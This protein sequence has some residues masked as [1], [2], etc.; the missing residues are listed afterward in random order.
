MESSPFGPGFSIEYDRFGNLVDFSASITERW[1][2]I[3]YSW[4][5]DTGYVSLASTGDYSSINFTTPATGQAFY[6]FS[7]I[8][9]T[10]NE[11]V[12]SL[13]EGTTYS[14]GS[15]TTP[16][17]YNRNI[18]DNTCTLTNVKTGNSA[19]SGTFTGGVEMF[20]SLVPGTAQGNTKP[21]GA[22]QSQGVLILKKNTNYTIKIMC[23][24]ATTLAGFIAV[25]IVNTL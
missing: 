9:K 2:Q 11:L 24:G 1:C 10:G 13:F 8:D 16:K 7:G 19:S 18:A 17:N 14:N 4:R 25:G 6:N 23:K 21:G 22:S 3:G 12:I 20:I 15:A 5:I